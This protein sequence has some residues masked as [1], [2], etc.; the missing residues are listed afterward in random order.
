MKKSMRV[1]YFSASESRERYFPLLCNGT[2]RAFDL[3][4]GKQLHGK[5]QYY[6]QH[7]CEEKTLEVSFTASKLIHL[8]P[9]SHAFV[10]K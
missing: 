3:W 9:L 5:K 10:A 4:T 8:V 6:L 7:V 1:R 2:L